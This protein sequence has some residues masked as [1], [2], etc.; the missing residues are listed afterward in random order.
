MTAKSHDAAFRFRQHTTIKG[1]SAAASGTSAYAEAGLPEVGPRPV[2]YA[3][4]SVIPQ[5]KRM[6]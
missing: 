5:L 3:P 4:I 6:A 2:G 1:R